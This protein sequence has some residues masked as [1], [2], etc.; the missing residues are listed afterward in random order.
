MRYVFAALITIFLWSPITLQAQEIGDRV[1]LVVR[2]I[3]IPGHPAPGINS[4]N[5]R[6][7][8]QSYVTV[9]DRDEATGWFN[10]VDVGGTDAWIT[11]TY[12]SLVVQTVVAPSDLCYRV[13]TW[14]L[15][16]FGS[17][18]SR[19]FPEYQ[20][21]GLTYPPRTVSE[22]GVI[23]AAIRDELDIKLLVLNEIDGD[24]SDESAISD[25]L[26][27]LTT[28]LGPTFTYVIGSSG[29][30]QRVAFVFDTQFVRPN[31]ITEISV[32]YTKIGGSDIF[33]RDPLVGNFSFIHEG[34]DQNDLVIVGLHLASG[35]HKTRNHD[36]AIDRLLTELNNLRS[37][38]TVIPEGEYDLILGGDLNA[39]MFDNKLEE[40]FGILDH[41][42]WDV[43]ANDPYPA[44]RLAGH[45]LAPKSQIDYLIAT[46][47]NGNR[48]GLVGEELSGDAA[49]VHHELA[50]GDWEGFRQTFSDHF[51]V[52][53]CVAVRADSD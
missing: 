2:D 7:P 34:V 11:P 51:P 48:H 40:F 44:S 6:F 14:N 12:I 15:E 29:K 24:G 8:S 41:G 38:G 53:T 47:V 21:G 31:A 10:V 23:A 37:V 43:L 49:T 46:R 26:D 50:D 36:A 52:T 39:S 35:Q 30:S 22:V 42:D 4:V 25:G 1:Q 19:G 20:W 9:I 28:L 18:K 33:A 17:N 32:P 27:T 3:G 5:H 13:G 45:P 16:W